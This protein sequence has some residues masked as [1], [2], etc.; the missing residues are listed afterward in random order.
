[1]MATEVRHS[2]GSTLMRLTVRCPVV[3]MIIS[4]SIWARLGALAIVKQPPKIET[5]LE[6]FKIR[7]HA[8]SS[9]HDGIDSGVEESEAL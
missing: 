7:D 5:S 2:K 6:G 4:F 9:L 8:T 1:M 3:M